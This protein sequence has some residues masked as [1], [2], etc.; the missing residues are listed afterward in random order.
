MGPCPFAVAVTLGLAYCAVEPVH[1]Y[2]PKRDLARL[3]V[4]VSRGSGMFTN[5][6]TVQGEVHI[7]PVD[8]YLPGCPTPG[9]AA[10]RRAQAAPANPRSD[11][12]RVRPVI[13]G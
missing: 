5:Y 6:A 8:I 7:G 2:G 1:S 12:T 11:P 4:G 10:G 13:S 9:D 3:G